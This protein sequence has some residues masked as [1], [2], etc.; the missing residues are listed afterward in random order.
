MGPKYNSQFNSMSHF[1]DSLD[2]LDEVMSYVSTTFSEADAQCL[3]PDRCPGTPKLPVGEITGEANKEWKHPKF[4]FSDFVDIQVESMLYRVPRAVMQES[5]GFR[6]NLPT[7]KSSSSLYVSGITT[8]EMEAF[9]DV[10]D[11]REVTG[12]DKFTFEQWAGALATANRLEI[13]R[14]RSYVTRRLQDSLSQLDP[15]DCIDIA[16]KYRVHEWLVQPS[17]RICER[18]EPLS[19]AEVLRLGSERTSAVCRVREKL[20]VYK[21]ESVV[22]WLRE[23]WPQNLYGGA[24]YNPPPLQWE[25]KAEAREAARA[26]EMKRLIELE[27]VLSKPDF[28]SPVSQP[29]VDTVP[30]GMPHPRYWQTDLRTIRVRNCLY[31]LPVRY[32]EKPSLLGEIQSHG[33]STLDPGDFVMVPHDV[34]VSDWNVF[35]EIVTA[36]PFDEPL[37]SLGFSS[38]VTGLRLA[39]R[40]GHDSARRYILQRMQTDFTE[41]DPIDLLE[42]AKIGDAAQS[43]WLQGLYKSLSQR[44]G[45]LSSEDMRRIGEK[46]MAEVWTLR[47]RYM[48]EA[49]QDGRDDVF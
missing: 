29:T 23:N 21:Y 36:R 49:G 15:F 1:D 12:D 31:Q 34:L 6:S 43:D 46:A 38:W 11:A 22:T 32:F 41:Q 24:W 10:S 4:H 2:E 7:N 47:D 25:A 48:W 8:Q 26:G 13:P 19:P 17:I 5:E 42:A 45:S 35:L 33:D 14:I 3:S 27:T 9:L 18:P 37:L 28:Q 20:S 30:Q 16:I 44:K 40:F 39:M